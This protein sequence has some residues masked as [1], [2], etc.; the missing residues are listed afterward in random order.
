MAFPKRQAH[1]CFSLINHEIKDA[2]HWVC[3]RHLSQIFSFIVLVLFIL[4][5][6]F[7][8]VGTVIWGESITGAA[9]DS[10]W[11]IKVGATFLGPFSGVLWYLVLSHLVLKRSAGF[12]MQLVV[13]LGT[14][15]VIYLLVATGVYHL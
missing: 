9:A 14:A 3:R 1:N 5:L 7:L 15:G 10:I 8:V 2:P 12:L 4:A 11:L 6:P 13:F